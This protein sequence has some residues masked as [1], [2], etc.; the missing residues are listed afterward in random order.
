VALDLVGLGAATLDALFLVDA[1][2]ASESL[3]RARASAIDGGGPVATALVAA[4][5]LGSRTALIDQLGND[6]VG[7]IAIE[8]LELEGVDVSAVKVVPGATSPTACVLVRR[9]DGSR[10]ISFSPGSVP[11]RELEDPDLD[12]VAAARCLHVNGRHWP[13]C[14]TAA[15]HARVCG[16]WVSFDGGAGRYRPHL[17][18]LVEISDVCIVARPFATASTGLADPV[19]ALLA[20]ADR[21]PGVTGVTDGA[22]GSWVK[23]VV[24]EPFHQPALR[25][26]E[27]VDTTGCGDAYHG[28]FLHALLSGSD[29]MEAAALASAVAALTASALGGRRGLPTLDT[30]LAFLR[31]AEP[32]DP[33]GR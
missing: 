3:Q 7:R 22:A 19:E 18:S 15:R 17:E 27:L 33:G 21:T 12:L 28:A 11:S 1:F 13:D 30:A 26:P 9:T 14:L 6:R 31:T 23:P 2:V 32:V 25:P 24:G 10:A 5:R 16:T 4:S 20:L 8:S 29:A